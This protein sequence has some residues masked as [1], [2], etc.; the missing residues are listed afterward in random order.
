MKVC[1]HDIRAVAAVEFALIGGTFILFICFWIELGL[2]LFM[3]TALDNAVRKEARLIKTGV[4]TASNQATFLANLCSDMQGLVPCGAFQVNVASGTSFA[5]LATST[6]VNSKNSFLSKTGFAPGASGQDVIVQ[7]A[8]A[9]TLNI[10]LVSTVFGT[11]GK[12]LIM[13]SLAFQNEPF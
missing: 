8:Y 6:A 2:S 11:N 3:Q 13:A 4:V 7:V 10:P 12:I 5:S 9:R 1:Q